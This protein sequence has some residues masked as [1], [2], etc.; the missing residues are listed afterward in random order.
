M[1]VFVE[2]DVVTH[3]LKGFLLSDL[4]AKL[5]VLEDN[6]GD[7]Q[8]CLP[9]VLSIHVLSLP[10]DVPD[11]VVVGDGELFK[12]FQKFMSLSHE[13]CYVGLHV[14]IVMVVGEVLSVEPLKFGGGSVDILEG[15]P[16]FLAEIV[17][18]PELLAEVCLKVVSVELKVLSGGTS[19]GEFP[20][21]MLSLDLL[22]SQSALETTVFL[23]LSLEVLLH[24]L[25]GHI[26]LV[27]VVDTSV[28]ASVISFEALKLSY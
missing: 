28:H 1:A 21:D 23:L 2:A 8:L 14:D 7:D 12:I 20:T 6:F 5:D 3:L 19:G 22:L 25:V 15:S 26:G 4:L 13:S 11:T 27:L 24:S 18:V 16:P 17:H 10:G 9:V